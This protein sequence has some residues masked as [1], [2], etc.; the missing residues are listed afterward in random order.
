MPDS[1]ASDFVRKF[2]IPGVFNVPASLFTLSPSFQE[3][4]V[5]LETLL[6]IADSS[7]LSFGRL[8]GDAS[9]R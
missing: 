2:L 8:L 4:M 3:E 7:A 1:R 9:G 5:Q 6:S